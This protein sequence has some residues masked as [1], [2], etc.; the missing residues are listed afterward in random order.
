MAP[1]VAANQP[2]EEVAMNTIVANV[3][4]HEAAKAETKSHPLKIIALFCGVGLVVSLWMASFGFDMSP[5][6]F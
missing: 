4:M 5:G 6:F 3:L 1:T 2:D